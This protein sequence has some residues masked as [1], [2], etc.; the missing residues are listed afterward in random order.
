MKVLVPVDGS[1]CSFNALRFATDFAK[2]YSATLHIVHFAE[3]GFEESDEVQEILEKVDAILTEED[4]HDESEVISDAWITPYRYA[5]R[6]GQDILRTAE[7]DE[8]DHIIMGHHGR[9]AIGRALMGS[10]SETVVKAA[11]IPVTVIP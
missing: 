11:E 8:Y 1:V 2:R 3:Q 10:A 6:V 5:N 4:I 9:G 7:E